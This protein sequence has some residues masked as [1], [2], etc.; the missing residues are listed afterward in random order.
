NPSFAL[1]EDNA[2]AIAEICQRLD[3]L[4]L[5]LE[6]AAARTG[7]LP[8]NLLLS[9]LRHRLPLLTH[10][11]RDLPERQQTL[12]NMIAWSYDLLE[13]RE[14]RLFRSLAVFSGGFGIDGAMAIE[15]EE[16]SDAMLDRL[17]SLVSKNLLRVESG[18]DGAP[19][20]FMLATI[21]EYAH[22][23]LEET[24]ELAPV[25]ERYVHFLLTL[26][27]AAEPHLYEADRDIWLRRLD[28]EEVNLYAALASCKD[29]PDIVATGLHLAGWLSMFWLQNGLL[30]EGL[31][32]METMLASA[33]ETDRSHARGKALYGAGLLSWKQA[34]A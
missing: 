33:D 27:Q 1:T 24:G 20:F 7:V 30:R 19:R 4:P 34:K 26:A 2:H 25:Q 22:E 18:F 28:S 10:G 15:S 5:A 3:G 21:Q 11:A 32:W 13:P 9:R 14:Q 12:R 6:L 29:D 8:P 16:Q 17:E 23:K 31:S